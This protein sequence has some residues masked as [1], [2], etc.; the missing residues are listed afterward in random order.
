MSN[1]TDSES[2][3]I[4]IRGRVLGPYSLKQLKIL[5]DRGQLS[6][7]HE[8]SSDGKSWQTAGTLNAVF[9]A[10]PKKS[11]VKEVDSA[12]QDKPVASGSDTASWYYSI[13]GNQEGPVE[14][15][16]LQEMLEFGRLNLND[17]VWKE[18][19]AEWVPATDVPDLNRTTALKRRT[20]R[21]NK[22]RS[23]DIS[24]TSSDNEL[25]PHFLDHL[26]IGVRNAVS[27]TFVWDSWKGSVELGRYAIYVS[28]I[29]NLA[30]CGLTAAKSNDVNVGLIGVAGAVIALVL[31]YSAVK[32]CG[33]IMRLI[34]ATALRMSS[35]AFL[36]S[37][38]LMFLVG[39]VLE[40]A[41]TGVVW[42][43]THDIPSLV[44]GI[45]ICL[46]CEQLGL[47]LLYPNTI[48]ITISD[49]AGPGEEAISIFSFFVMLPL[50]FVPTVFGVGSAVSIIGT[51][52][53]LVLLLATTESDWTGPIPY[54]MVLA[55]YS[56]S[57]AMQCAAFPITMYVYFVIA[58]LL[59]D[60][61]SSILVMPDKLDLMALKIAPN[62][63]ESKHNGY[64]SLTESNSG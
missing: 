41:G 22:D 32:S 15:T 45:A 42:I 25:A 54:A 56:T 2:Y 58:Y 4:R 28:I 14:L 19:M 64:Q 47:M 11:T 53:A 24:T 51:V 6:Q 17:L 48:G 61:I 50:R 5:R 31:Q 9:E 27:E 26:L 33:A 21:T 55:I 46:L 62:S 13:D 8:I 18:G 44:G 16:S 49:R 43:R 30:F 35:T 38:A 10:A 52:V 1:T 23:D 39:G 20:K 40:L 29:L 7:S 12:E 59:V 3:H 36:D 57:I 37:M 60:V 34:R 63:D